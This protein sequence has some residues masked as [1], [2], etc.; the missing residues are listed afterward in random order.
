MTLSG[1]TVGRA[2]SVWLNWVVFT[3]GPKVCKKNGLYGCYY[4]FR[5]IVLHTLGLL[6]RNLN[7]AN[8]T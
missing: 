3:W 1:E 5:A 7:I 8:I 4:G 2:G 6:L